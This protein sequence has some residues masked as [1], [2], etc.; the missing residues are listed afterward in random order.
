MMWG[1]T[2]QFCCWLNDH[3]L[4]EFRLGHLPSERKV[5]GIA[6]TLFFFIFNLF[7]GAGSQGVSWLYPTEINSIEYR[8]TGMSYGVATN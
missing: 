1:T 7:F 3:H 4:P 8:I 6:A 2:G 5:I